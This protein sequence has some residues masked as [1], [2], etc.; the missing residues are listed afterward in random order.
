MTD[1]TFAELN[2]STPVLKGLDD[3]GFEAP[4]EIQAQCIP[5]LMNRQDV[6]GQAQ[7]GTGKTAAFGIPLVEQ[8]DT[9]AHAVQAVI[10]CPTRELAIQ[11]TG[12]LQK[13]GKHINGLKVVPVYGGQPIGRQIKAIK[14]GAQVVVG[15]PGRTIDHLKRGTLKLDAV[16]KVVL[17]EADEMLNMGFR[18]DIE[19]ILSFTGGD[20]QTIMFSATMSKAIKQIMRRFMTNPQTV[21][22]DRKKMTAPKI[23]QYV[24]EVRDSVRTE[25]LCRFMDVNEFKLALVFCNTKRMTEKLA[26]E[27]QSR[28]YASDVINGDLRQRQ[29]DKVMNRF[30]KGYIDILVA[31]DVAARGIDVDDVD[32][33][34]NYDVPQDPEYYVHRIGRTGRA[35]RSGTAYTFVSGRKNKYLRYVQ[36]QIKMKL[37][38]ISM[39]SVKDVE[40]SK[41]EGFMDQVT[42]TLEQGGLRSYIE[43]IEAVAE[44]QFTTAEIAGALLKMHLNDEEETNPTDNPV[45][46]TSSEKMQKLFF[47]LGKKNKIHPGDFVGAISGETSVDGSVIGHIDIYPNHSFVDVPTS[48]APEIIRVMNNVKVKGKRVKVKVA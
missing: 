18:D 39:P 24:V 5:P 9:Q 3:M 46:S 13:I 17:D 38:V 42:E 29:R 2:L 10:M 45:L 32:V 11:V 33:V 34:F 48:T 4:S 47:S 37:D 25:A 7:T 1:M 40:E 23:D 8:I 26:R 16:N 15:T 31:T 41:V 22:I 21:T 30:R 27:L 6:V 14:R 19:K 36:K 20:Q 43:Q 28:G 12:E 44:G 35:G